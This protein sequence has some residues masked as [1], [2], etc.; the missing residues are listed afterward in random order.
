[1]SEHEQLNI[2]GSRRANRQSFAAVV[3]FRSGVRRAEV[4]VRDV[5]TLGAR[6]SGVF[7]VRQG[8]QFFLKLP[9]IEAIAAQVVWVEE[10]EFGCEFA[11]PLSDV[12]LEA[13]IRANP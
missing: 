13:I 2:T 5:S 8:D 11:R 7:L 12:V 10:F 9:M 4:K 1:M 3:Q 6:I